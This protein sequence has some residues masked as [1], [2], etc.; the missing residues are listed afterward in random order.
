MFDVVRFWLERGV[1]GF[2]IDVAHYI[3]KD[4][5]M[6]DNPVDPNPKGM[7]RR[8]V[9]EYD[10]FVHVHDKGHP[11]THVVFREF[12]QLLDSYS[13]EQPRFSVGE[14]HIFDWQKW[15]SYYGKNLDELHMPFNFSLLNVAW[16]AQEIREVVETLEAAIPPGAWPNYVLG[17]HDYWRIATR[18]GEAQARVAVM[19]LLTLRGTPT[20]YYGEEI[21]MT[22]VPVPPERE[23]DPWGLN[24]PGYSRDPCRTPMQWSAGPNAGFSVPETDELWLPLASDYEAV[25][26]ERQLE[27]PASMLSLYR[28]LLAYRK[29]TPALQWGDYQPVDT[30]S[31]ACYAFLRQAGDE[32]VLVALNFSGEE[33]QVGLPGLGAGRVAISTHLDRTEAVDGQSLTLRGDEGVIVELSGR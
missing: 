16:N 6:R 32:H 1:D 17:N 30:A 21:G 13:A 9:R 4:P 29:G 12:R 10:R 33:Q 5:E 15:A 27:D 31:E 26:V 20:I 7:L 25:N 14:I 19:V 2:R 18:Y 24:Q 23:Q 22:D 28:R 11:D 3:M 8:P